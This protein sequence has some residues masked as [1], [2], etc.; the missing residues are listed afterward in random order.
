MSGYYP[1]DV[2]DAHPHFNPPAELECDECGEP[3]QEGGVACS[4]CG[5]YVLTDDER[6]EAAED[7]AADLAMDA[8]REGEI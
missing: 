8:M 5:E 6:R 1:A 7:A 2:T 4:N 3:D